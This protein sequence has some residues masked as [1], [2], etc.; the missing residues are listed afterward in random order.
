MLP[1]SGILC[2]ENYFRWEAVV[3]LRRV[4]SSKL[5]VVNKSAIVPYN[6][7]QMFELVSDVLSYPEFLPWCSATRLLSRDENELCGELEV[8]RI[9]VRQKFSTIN[10]LYPFERIDLSLREGPFKKLH[11]GWRFT[12]LG[13]AACK[14]ELTLE[15]EFSGR[16]INAAFGKVFS[17]I[18]NTMVGAFCKRANEVYRGD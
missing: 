16:L 3:S 14:V 7:E 11:G 5:P 13:E 9:G 15:F 8:S 18:A 4:G 17:H 1:G 12:P 10:R 2:S 6:T